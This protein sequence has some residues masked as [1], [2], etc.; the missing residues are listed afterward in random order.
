M[1]RMVVGVVS[2]LV[3]SAAPAIAQDAE[4]CKD[5]PL[6]TRFPNMHITDCQSSQFD[7]RAFPIGAARQG[8]QTTKSVEVEGPVHWISYEVNEGTTPPSGLQIMRNFEAA[9]KKAGGTIEGSDP[10]GARPTTT[11]SAC[12][13]W[14]TAA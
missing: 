14:A 1:K 5:H 4:G 2:L 11:R 7:V 12:P 9:A 6:F 3:L 13:T 8:R 10:A